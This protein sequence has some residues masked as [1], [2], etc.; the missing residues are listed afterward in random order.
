MLTPRCRFQVEIADRSGS[1]IAT[2]LG[3]SGENLLS[4]SMK[5]E[6][7]YEITKI[8]N[9]VMPLQPIQSTTEEI[10]F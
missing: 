5:A 1:I 8:K 4:F 7:I 10:T 9:E 2:I 6:Q 3:E